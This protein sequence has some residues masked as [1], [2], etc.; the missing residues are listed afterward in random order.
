MQVDNIDFIDSVLVVKCSGVFGI[1]SEG[2]PSGSLLTKS[3]DEWMLSHPDERVEELVID[4]SD[5]EYSWGDGPVSSMIP[6]ISAV[7]F[8]G[9]VV[10]GPS[11]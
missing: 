9:F 5:V 2:N 6:F 1:G 4:Y 8:L 11:R 7:H 10:E 3:I